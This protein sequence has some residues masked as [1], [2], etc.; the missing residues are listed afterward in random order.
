MTRRPKVQPRDRRGQTPRRQG[1]NPRRP[2]PKSRWADLETDAKTPGTG[3]R[4]HRA[5]GA[6][7]RDQTSKRQ[8]HYAPAH[9]RKN[10]AS[11]ESA[12]QDPPAQGRAKNSRIKGCTHTDGIFLPLNNEV[13][14]SSQ[15]AI[16]Y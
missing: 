9:Y 2:I 11:P 4:E 10:P 3:K 5:L 1:H 13:G 12:H 6:P 15:Y 14:S 16:G 8:G 7:K